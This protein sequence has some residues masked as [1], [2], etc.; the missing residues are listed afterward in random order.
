M[1]GTI[2][3]AGKDHVLVVTKLTVLHYWRRTAQ[4]KVKFG[5]APRRG[6]TIKAFN[7]KY[8]TKVKTWSEIEANADALIKQLIA[9][10]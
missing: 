8:G 2:G 9:Q 1:S 4:M 3:V 7:E 5:A 10:T 6:W